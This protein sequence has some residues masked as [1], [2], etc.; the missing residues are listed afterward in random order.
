MNAAAP[1]QATNDAV[2]YAVPLAGNRY[3]LVRLP[4]DL[5]T[6]KFRPPS[7][8]V[9]DAANAVFNVAA[10]ET[11]IAYTEGGRQ[12][13]LWYLSLA[14]AL[15]G[16]FS[17]GRHI[18]TSSSPL[19]V[20]SGSPDAAHLI[21]QHTEAGFG[22]SHPVLSILPAAGGPGVEISAPNGTRVVPYYA[23]DG[24]S[25]V[26]RFRTATGTSFVTVDPHTGLQASTF[27]VNDTGVRAFD[28]LP[29]NGWVWVPGSGDR[30]RVQQNEREPPHD[31]PIPGGG[32]A[33]NVDA[34]P[35]GSQLLV[36][37]SSGRHPLATDSAFMT[38]IS[39]R[40]GHATR[41][42][43]MAGVNVGGTWLADGSLMIN[44]RESSKSTTLFRVRG[45]G[46]ME[47]LGTIP[48]ANVAWSGDGLHIA[49]TTSVGR[50]DIWLARNTAVR[51]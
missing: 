30:V 46:R 36:W 45:P 42:L 34:S 18:Y 31:Y 35:D 40:D 47:R 5:R 17:S 2:W 33:F 15:R 48:S 39:L 16:Q 38:V 27:V 7:D 50:G 51:P 37:S 6:G 43:A 41:W 28:P 25:V 11:A 21:V 49:V 10:N 3:G 29:R 1:P 24:A 12:Y 32:Y 22:N 23:P 26:F 14:D 13:D 9:L 8:T 20:T 19:V 4:V 44:K